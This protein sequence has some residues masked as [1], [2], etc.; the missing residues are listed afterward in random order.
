MLCEADP[1]ATLRHVIRKSRGSC[2]GVSDLQMENA[3]I[4]ILFPSETRLSAEKLLDN[5]T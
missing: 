2:F 3:V 5:G 1:A 4:G